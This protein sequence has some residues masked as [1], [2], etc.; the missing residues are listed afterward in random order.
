MLVEIVVITCFILFAVCTVLMIRSR[1]HLEKEAQELKASCQKWH[2][3]Y[4]EEKSNGELRYHSKIE[5]LKKNFEAAHT[6]FVAQALVGEASRNL[7]NQIRETMDRNYKRLGQ[8]IIGDLSDIS[9]SN[10]GQFRQSLIDHVWQTVQQYKGQIVQHPFI[11][12]KNARVVFTQND[13]TAVLVEQE[14]QVRSVSFTQVSTLEANKAIARSDLG[15]RFQLAFPYVYFLITFRQRSLKNIRLYF[16]NKA[17]MTGKDIVAWAPLPNVRTPNSND[18]PYVCMGKTFEVEDGPIAEQCKQIIDAYW[19]R[20]YNRDL[21]DGGYPS[22]SSKLANLAEWQ[23]NS[24][25][26]PLFILDIKWPHQC[27][28]KD[29]LD[30]AF[31]GRDLCML[32]QATEQLKVRLNDC[33]TFV[34]TSINNG[35]TTAK[36]NLHLEDH[37]LCDRIRDDLE[38][39]VTTHAQRV[40]HHCTTSF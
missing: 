40:F 16:A 12:P 7:Q 11:I 20:P 19:Q 1:I 8:S 27:K 29:V 9:E 25:K 32:D 18:A 38:K 22:I 24:Q 3:A 17:I 36:E 2:N 10:L 15:Y 30:R 6:H 13:V 33:S 37:K 35:I 4:Q 34:S 31:A 23:A 28:V 21:G 14:P 39:V 26:N 5:A